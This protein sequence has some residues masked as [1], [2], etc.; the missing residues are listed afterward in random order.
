MTA[1][2][3]PRCVLVPFLRCAAASCEDQAADLAAR[4]ALERWSK[5]EQSELLWACEAAKA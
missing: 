1:G 3:T 2:V 5:L 4:K